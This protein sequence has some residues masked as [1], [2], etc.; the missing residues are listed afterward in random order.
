VHDDDATSAHSTTAATAVPL[1]ISD[2]TWDAKATSL[3]AA[4]TVYNFEVATTHTYFVG[5]ESGGVWVHNSCAGPSESG[6]PVVIG[7]GMGRVTQYANDNGFDYYTPTSNYGGDLGLQLNG[8][9][10][11]L[12]GVMDTGRQIVDI[13]YPPEDTGG[14]VFFQLEQ[15]S[16]TG[17]PW[18]TFVNP[19]Y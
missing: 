18:L 11:W 8:N 14:S 2:I 5:T 1:K 17:Y 4:T 9:Q 7:R 13:G 16:T 10:E 3:S 6:N 19:G 12:D 15:E